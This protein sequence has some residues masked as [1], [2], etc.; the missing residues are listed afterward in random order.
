MGFIKRRLRISLSS[1]LRSITGIY[2]PSSYCSVA[3]NNLQITL[4][5]LKPGTGYIYLNGILKSNDNKAIVLFIVIVASNGS[6]S[7]GEPYIFTQEPNF[8]KVPSTIQ[9]EFNTYSS[10]ENLDTEE[11]EEIDGG[12]Q[13]VKKEKIDETFSKFNA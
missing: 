12:S 8:D 5:S 4:T 10:V 9:K 3:Y 6:L 2:H 13:S 11:P 7:T 1:H